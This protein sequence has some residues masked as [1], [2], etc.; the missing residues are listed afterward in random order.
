MFQN[1]FRN[2]KLS[3]FANECL[4][5]SYDCGLQK[6]QS[7]IVL[8]FIDS[9][10]LDTFHYNKIFIRVL[11]VWYY[12]ESNMTSILGYHFTQLVLQDVEPTQHSSTHLLHWGASQVQHESSQRPSPRTSPGN[13]VERDQPRSCETGAWWDE[14]YREIT[15]QQATSITM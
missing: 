10:V 12:I 8:N 6:K 4:T 7:N 13:P 15:K 2:A 11:T 9:M 5:S 3:G 1:N 14:Q